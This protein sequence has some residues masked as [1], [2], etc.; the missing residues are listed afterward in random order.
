MRENDLNQQLADS[1]CQSGTLNGRQL[2]RGQCV[3]LLDGRAVAVEKDLQSALHALRKLDPNPC[4]GM[5]FEVAPPVVD[6]I[7]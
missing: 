1:I 2:Q 7:R 5:V 6:V 3:A 4:R